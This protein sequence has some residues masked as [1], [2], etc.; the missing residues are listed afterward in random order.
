MFDWIT[1]LI[2]EGGYPAI[3]FLMFLENVFPPIPSELIMPMAGFKAAQG[4]LSLPLVIASGSV[5]ALAGASVWYWL[6]RMLGKKGVERFAAQH[7]RWL[8]MCPPDVE[9]A[10]AWFARHGG[11]AVLIGR[12]VPAVRSAISLPAGINRMSLPKFFFLSFVGTSI[13]TTFLVL[14]G[15]LLEARHDTVS[16]YLNPISNAIFVAL[17]GWYVYRVVTFRA[18]ENED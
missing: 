13:W 5:G 9:R 17:A 2:E 8:T 18:S 15:Y 4:S 7:G 3:A 11:K 6:G 14:A 10:D 12:V 1:K 16:E